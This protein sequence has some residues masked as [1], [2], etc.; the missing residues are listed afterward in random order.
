[1]QGAGEK[2]GENGDDIKLH[3]ALGICVSTVRTRDYTVLPAS[4]SARI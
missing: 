2:L 3:F 4:V 1:M